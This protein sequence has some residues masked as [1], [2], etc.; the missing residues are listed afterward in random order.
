MADNGSGNF[1]E[2]VLILRDKIAREG[3]EVPD[4][5]IDYIA[6]RF[7][8][9]PQLKS[10]LINISVFA[11]RRGLPITVDVAR[12]YVEGVKREPNAAAVAAA[13]EFAATDVEPSEDTIEVSESPAPAGIETSPVE[14]P[15]DAEVRVEDDAHDP[16]IQNPPLFM[17]GGTSVTSWGD[18]VLPLNFGEDPFPIGDESAT[19][20]AA[21]DAPAPDPVSAE[22]MAPALV[23]PAP[24]LAPVVTP[25]TEPVRTV[26]TEPSPIYFIPLRTERKRSLTDRIGIALERAGLEKVVTPGD[27]VAVKVHFGEKGNTGFVSSIYAREVVARIKALGGKPFLTDANTLYS[28]QRA[29]AVDHM[30]C[31]LANGFSYA[32]V[33]API[34]IA[35]GLNGQD[36]VEIALTVGKHCETVKIGAQAVHADSMVVISHVKGHGEAGFGGAIKNVGMG[37]G[38]RSAKQ[39]MHS[40]VK[41]HVQQDKCTRCGR[42]VEWCP[43]HC[44]DMGP[45]RTDKAYINQDRCIGCGECVAACS[46][47]AIAI[48]WSGNPAAMQEK[49]VEH[50]VGALDNKREKVAFVSFLTNISPECDC[51]SFSDA[52][53]VPDIGILVGRDIVAIDQASYDMVTEAV[54]NQHSAGEGLASGTDKFHSIHGVDGQIAIRYAEELGLGTRAYTIKRVG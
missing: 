49:M 38:T 54:G 30:E 10:A 8:G 17:V 29:N 11:A 50:A 21:P 22:P 47:G 33:G 3:F 41:P 46:Y 51:W 4:E 40:D 48:N 1:E 34:I 20:P 27:M 43:V 15:E 14:S 28:G 52:P 13:A 2:R 45:D 35:D 53:I 42:C 31:A 7:S 9:A 6:S 25:T 16:T 23:T 5:V 18:G 32:T 24:S 44:I 19:E 36:G 26:S 39:R 37:L 12:L